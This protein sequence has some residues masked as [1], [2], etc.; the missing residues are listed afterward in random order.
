MTIIYS[1]K[2]DDD[3]I[4]LQR[5]WQNIPNVNV[6]EITPQS[7]DWEGV[8][9]SA[10]SNEDDT[11]IFLGHGTTQGLLFPNFDSGEYI[12]HENN[13]GLIHAKN[14]ICCWCYASSFCATHNLH[15][16]ATSMFI[17][18]EQ[19]ACDNGIYNYT[20]EQINSNSTRFY[21]EINSF[22]LNQV[23]LDEWVMRLG[24]HMDIENAIDVFNRQ[25][26]SYQ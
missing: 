8:V 13:V 9:D 26:L 18:N 15:S 16:F 20:Q 19:E 4:I 11:L 14:V 23:P 6:V 3:C 5:V 24:A 12:L 21:S 1:N 10:I 2:Q 22:L 7:E 25:C 17:S